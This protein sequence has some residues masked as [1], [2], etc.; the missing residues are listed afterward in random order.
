MA[1]CT[2]FCKVLFQLVLT[3]LF[4]ASELVA[5]YVAGSNVLVADAFH[6]FSD[7]ISLT[8]SLMAIY[9]K[10]QSAQSVRKGFGY[11]RAEPL[12]ALIHGALLVGLG[13]SIATGAIT[14]II[15]PEKLED[16]LTALIVGSVGF[17]VDTCGLVLF[18]QDDLENANMNVRSLFLE[19]IGDFVGT[20]VVVISCA[21]AYVYS[22]EDWVQY[23]DPIGSLTM[24]LIL[25]IAARSI[26]I[27]TVRILMNDAPK[28]F[29]VTELTAELENQTGSH[30][31]KLNLYQIDA[32]ELVGSVVLLPKEQIH[33]TTALEAIRN[34]AIRVMRK[35]GSVFETNNFTVQVGAE[36]SNTV[37]AGYMG[38]GIYQNDAPE[39][40]DEK[41]R[42][43]ALSM[44]RTSR[45][46]SRVSIRKEQINP[47][48]EESV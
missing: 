3:A 12:G 39:R 20:S 5:G 41:S 30:V 24:A 23:I 13:F 28:D 14:N 29:P 42:H 11:R 36:A 22:E 43:R 18:F 45:V 19:K 32:D 15:N 27:M 2:N 1:I 40:I 33:T 8:V 25:L 16:P 37:Y 47:V 6:M 34:T 35:Y 10:D 4:C 46:A 9:K 44:V 21:L 31:S 38:D 7:V 48:Y 17:L 26:F